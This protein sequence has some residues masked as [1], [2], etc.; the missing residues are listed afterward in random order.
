MT[1]NEALKLAFPDSAKVVRQTLFLDDEQV[2][3]IQKRARTKLDSKIITYYT[4]AVGSRATAFAFFEKNTIR[5]K[6]EILMIV[7]NADGT[8]K[9][10]EML[11]FYEP[12]DYLPIPKWFGLFQKK[13]LTDKLWPNHDIHNITGATLTVQAATLGVRKILA[14][15]EV[16]IRQK[17]EKNVATDL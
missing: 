17:K 2:E 10:I 3:Q 1:Q 16:A 9:F 12:F 11:A 5:T 6:D 15:Y 14:L 13:A 4:D 7:L 8:V